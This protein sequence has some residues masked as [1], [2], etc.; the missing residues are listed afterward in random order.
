LHSI[1]QLPVVSIRCLVHGTKRKRKTQNFCGSAVEAYSTA[2][3]W[4]GGT[5]RKI[6]SFYA[7]AAQSQ[8][9][10][11]VKEAPDEPLPFLSSW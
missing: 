7:F 10:D 5:N 8:R 3:Q 2:V 9:E 4:L 11:V 6:H 1:A